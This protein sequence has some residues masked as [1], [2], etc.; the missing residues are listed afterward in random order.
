MTAKV[1]KIHLWVIL[2]GFPFHLWTRD[3]F[4]G[5]ANKIGHF[6]HLEESKLWAFD[7]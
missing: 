7:K 4:V 3:I 1:T 2:Q 5:V 6:V